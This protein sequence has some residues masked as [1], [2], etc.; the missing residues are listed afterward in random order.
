MQEKRSRSFVFWYA[1]AAFV[2]LIFGASPA[3]AYIDP[4][5]GSFI[6]QMLLAGFFA[7]MFGLRQVRDKIK[8]SVIS[9]FSKK[10]ENDPA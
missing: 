9:K 1:F 8:V 3:Y 7:L 6:L 10:N 5:S 4:G 2:F